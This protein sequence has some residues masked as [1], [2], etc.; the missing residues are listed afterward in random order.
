MH[1]ESLLG[2]AS[3]HVIEISQSQRM[4]CV[5]CQHASAAGDRTW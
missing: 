4:V 3:G 5:V 1:L 2:G